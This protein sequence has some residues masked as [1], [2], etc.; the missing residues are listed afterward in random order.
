MK[1]V[2][3]QQYL[4]LHQSLLNE[5]AA[6]EARLAQVAKALSGRAVAAAATKPPARR[7]R[8]SGKATAKPGRKPGR[9]RVQNSMSMREAVVKVLAGKTLARREVLAGVLKLGYK[10]NTK[11]PLNSLG[12][13]LYKDKAIKL[14]NGKFSLTK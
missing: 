3:V 13:I 4:S 8:P 12:V 6:L 7:G 1:N 11:D 14:A 9:K 10:F 2:N 5:K